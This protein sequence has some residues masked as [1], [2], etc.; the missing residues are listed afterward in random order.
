M[1][2]VTEPIITEVEMEELRG[3]MVRELQKL[4]YICKRHEAVDVVAA[5][6]VVTL[7]LG[8]ELK[9]MNRSGLALN[10]GTGL[11]S[12]E[13]ESTL[14]GKAVGETYTTQA[15]GVSVTVTVDG[16]LRTVIPEI[17]DELIRQQA[18]D[19]VETVEQYKKLL[20]KKTKDMYHGFYTEWFALQLLN[21]WCEKSEIAIDDE[22]FSEW[23]ARWRQLQHER[24]EFHHTTLM[25]S[26]P[27]QLEEMLCEDV[28]QLMR[29]AL[30]DSYFQGLD[31]RTAEPDVM[32]QEAVDRMQKR[33]LAPLINYLSP[34]VQLDWKEETDGSL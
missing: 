15:D 16:C 2:L 27:G 5:G 18:I 26:Y 22:E 32:D 17:S 10:V 31:Y 3:E 7:T 14:P 1:D 33:V 25:E 9:K 20:E 24:N 34:L 11:F 19:G 6:D 30:L 4:Q 21:D 29:V 28:T 12:K 8:S 13:L 23:R